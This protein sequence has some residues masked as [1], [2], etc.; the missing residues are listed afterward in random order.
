M[1]ADIFGDGEPEPPPL[2]GHPLQPH[3]EVERQRFITVH[4]KE[5]DAPGPVHGAKEAEQLQGQ[6]GRGRVVRCA[7]PVAAAHQGRRR[8][9]AP[10]AVEIMSSCVGP[11]VPPDGAVGVDVGDDT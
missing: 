8:G 2:D 4:I 7:G 6:P 5:G 9:G 1:V 3:Q 11:Q 10:L